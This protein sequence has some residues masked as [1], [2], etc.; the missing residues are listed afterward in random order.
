MHDSIKL[1]YSLLAL[2]L[3]TWA[4]QNLLGSHWG[5]NEV[6]KV[7][8]SHSIKIQD[9]YGFSSS[10][11]SCVSSLM[12]LAYITMTTLRADCR[13]HRDNDGISAVASGSHLLYH[14]HYSRSLI[15][16]NWNLFLPLVAIT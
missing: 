11:S 3:V 9:D 4:G 5:N 12:H 15:A 10:S 6:N 13:V 14:R 8:L 16:V 2:V 7:L 1:L